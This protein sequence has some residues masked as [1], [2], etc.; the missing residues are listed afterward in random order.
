M[1]TH[2][3]ALLFVAAT[4]LSAC[5]KTVDSPGAGDTATPYGGADASANGSIGSTP[6]YMNAAGSDKNPNAG[7]PAAAAAAPAVP[8][9]D[10]TAA[11]A[12]ATAPA[13]KP[14]AAH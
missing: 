5:G 11:P 8:A 2:R 3:L 10:S 13:A 6:G 12:A 14:P 7:K 4:L 9:A 1:R